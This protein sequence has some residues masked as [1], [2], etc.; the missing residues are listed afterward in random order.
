MF[1]HQHCTPALPSS[2]VMHAPNSGTGF[3]R[4]E[5]ADNVL[6]GKIRNVDTVPWPAVT[7]RV[8]SSSS[9][10]GCQTL[11]AT[12]WH[13]SLTPPPDLHM[14]PDL[15]VPRPA[16]TV[17]VSSRSTRLPN[18]AGSGFEQDTRR[19]PSLTH[20]PDSQM[21]PDLTHICTQALHTSTAKRHGVLP[22]YVDGPS[23][24]VQDGPWLTGRHNTWACGHL[25]GQQQVHR[26]ECGNI[27]SHSRQMPT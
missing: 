2:A 3:H 12:R 10:T 14:H 25:T 19:H 17:R 1:V 11:Q 24:N 26:H 15:T 27:R 9:S 22:S 16:V 8:S 5:D 6:C 18:P 21:H 4:S 20:P 23:K 7:V 13:P